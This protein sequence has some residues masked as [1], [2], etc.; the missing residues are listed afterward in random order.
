MPSD[1]EYKATKQIMLGKAVMNPDFNEL[2]NFIDKTFGVKTINIIYDTIDKEKRPRLN[3]CFEFEW[4]KQSFNEN[5]GNFNFDSKKQEV[6]ANKF[7]QTLREQK[8]EKNK[9]LFDFIT[10]PKNEKYKTANIFVYYS[11]F[12]PIARDEANESIPQ[13]KIIQLKQELNNKDL[14]EIS[15]CFSGTTFFL[16]TDQQVKEY[17]NSHT[18][19][20]W[21]DRYFD[22]LE[23]YNE[24]GYFKRDNFSVYLD[25]KENLDTNYESNWY[26]YYK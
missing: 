4:E 12:A 1:K 19:K 13:S 26:Y 14:W 23:L 2:S 22:L 25:S 9:G 7:R 8:I 18:R 21:A 6:I 3:I 20:L 5:N 16:Y 24:F 10:K 15:R 11:A 17:E